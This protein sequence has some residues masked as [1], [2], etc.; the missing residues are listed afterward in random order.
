MG[1]G[2]KIAPGGG[3]GR[4]GYGMEGYLEHF[5]G[6]VAGGVE[7]G[8]LGYDV[9]T[10]FGVGDA[11]PLGGGVEHFDGGF[12]G[13]DEGV[14]AR[15]NGHLGLG[16]VEVLVKEFLELALAVGEVVGGEAPHVHRHGGLGVEDLLFAVFVLEGDFVLVVVLDGGALY[17]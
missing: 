10:V 16:H 17:Y 4:G 8:E 1:E 13:A 9:G 5:F 3:A 2:I 7:G 14:D 6:V 15:G 11:E 12:A